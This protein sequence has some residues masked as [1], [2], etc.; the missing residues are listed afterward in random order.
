M[1]TYIKIR[2]N[3]MV[4][5]ALEFLSK[6]TASAVCEEEIV[7]SEDIPKG[8]KFALTDIKCGEEILKY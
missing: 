6:A 5:V 8:H 1:G 7:L 2:K 3:D 4:A